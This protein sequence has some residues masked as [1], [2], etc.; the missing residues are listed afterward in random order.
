[1]TT[2]PDNAT[3]HFRY[4]KLLS[5][6]HRNEPARAE[7]GRALDLAE[8]NPRGERWLWEAHHLL[9]RVLGPRPEAAPHWEAF[10]KLGPLDSPYRAEGNAFLER[11]NRPWTGN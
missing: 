1:V 8:K 6:N 10:L 3:W 5:A 9:A 7:L 11:M 2:Q 4:G